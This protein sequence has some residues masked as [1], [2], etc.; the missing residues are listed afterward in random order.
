M[1]DSQYSFLAQYATSASKKGY[2]WAS[3]FP[4]FSFCKIK[5]NLELLRLFSRSF[6]VDCTSRRHIIRT[7]VDYEQ[8][9]VECNSQM[10]PTCQL[11][12]R[13]V[14]NFSD[15]SLYS[16]TSKEPALKYRSNGPLILKGKFILTSVQYF[17]LQLISTLIMTTKMV[18]SSI[19][20][21]WYFP[22]CTTREISCDKF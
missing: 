17:I 18:C 16:N 20:I 11:L 21:L 6:S 10:M 22:N 12:F 19:Y 14:T 4:K 7:S 5:Q 1:A 15:I 8:W 3:R 9:Q 13:S 2:P